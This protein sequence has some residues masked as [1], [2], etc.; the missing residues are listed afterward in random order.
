MSDIREITFMGSKEHI[1]R[2]KKI[3]NDYIV[4]E[5]GKEPFSLKENNYHYLEE[6]A[7]RVISDLKGDGLTDP[8]IKSVIECINEKLKK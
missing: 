5:N 4:S 1:D 3:F 8:E 7:D 2:I 6:T